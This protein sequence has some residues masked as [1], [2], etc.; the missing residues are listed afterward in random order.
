MEICR[1]RKTGEQKI[2]FHGEGINAKESP[3]RVV[4][5]PSILDQR[6][7]LV[8]VFQDVNP[9]GKLLFTKTDFEI[10]KPRHKNRKEKGGDK[11]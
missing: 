1:P 4:K 7:P 6:S 10:P 3:R 9:G 5:F 11:L 2:I 8:R